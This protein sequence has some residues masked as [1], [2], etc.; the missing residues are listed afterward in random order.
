MHSIRVCSPGPRAALHLKI[1]EEIERRSGNRLTE[2]VEALAYHYSQTD[3]VDKAFTFV[4]MAGAKSLGVYS[5]DEADQYFAVASTLLDKNP[6][7]ADDQQIAALL[8]DWTLCLHLL[9]RFKSI[10]EVVARFIPSLDRLGDDPKRI[11]VLHQYV[12]ALQWSGLYREAEREQTKLS[13]AVVGLSDMRSKAYALA[14]AFY[15]RTV[16]A[17]YSIET[18]EALSRE[19]IA[20]ASAVEDPYIQCFVRYVV[21]WEEVHRGAWQRRVTS[22]EDLIAVGRRMNDPRSLG[23]GLWL[24]SWISLVGDDYDAALKFR[25]DGHRRRKNTDRPSERHQR[26]NPGVGFAQATRC[27]SNDTA[28]GCCNARSTVGVIR[29][30]AWTESV[31]LPWFCMERSARESVGSSKRFRDERTKAIARSQIGTGCSCREIYLEIIAGTEKPP[32][33]VLARNLITLVA[34]ML[35]AQK[36]I[37]SLVERVRQNP[38]FDPNGHHIGRCEMIMGLLYKAK[39]KRALAVQHLTEAKRI[40]SQFGPTPMLAKIEAALA[41]LA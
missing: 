6:R 14:S 12:I 16:V 19:A 18:F 7:C 13:T 28:T 9:A 22:A 39:K 25:R 4:A 11:L 17:P 8:A 24:Q 20:A 36:R 41:E 32:T 10:T 15:I 33:K 2:V 31:A 29:L 37:S 23:F 38:Q 1:V 40:A 34:V 35:T 5:L 26:K 30:L 3:R 21:G 27:S